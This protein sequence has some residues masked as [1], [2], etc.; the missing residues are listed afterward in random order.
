MAPPRSTPPGD[1][2]PRLRPGR[3]PASRPPWAADPRLS[4]PRRAPQTGP[5]VF[6]AEVLEGETL[7]LGPVPAW[8]LPVR[9]HDGATAPASDDAPTPRAVP[10][11]GHALGANAN[12]WRVG[13]QEPRNGA[14]SPVAANRR[15]PTDLPRRRPD[16]GSGAPCIGQP[17]APAP[18]SQPSRN[19]GRRYGVTVGTA[20]EFGWFAPGEPSRGR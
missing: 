17:P 11:D 20:A 2:V 9:S 10:G 16:R 3:G 4:A 19:A 8:K 12:E 14:G 7:Q 5:G 13:S 6:T 1:V 15:E 18:A